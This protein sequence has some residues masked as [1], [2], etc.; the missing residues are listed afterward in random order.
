[1]VMYHQNRYCMPKGTYEPGKKVRI[2]TDEATGIIRFFDFKEGCIIEE[3]PIS[4]GIGK[5]IRNNHPERDKFSN[6]KELKDKVLLGFG[7]NKQS[8]A[9][10][11]TIL[12]KKARYTRDQLSI[13]SKLQDRYTKDELER[14]VSY[15]TEWSLYSASD[16][17]DTL[18]YL[19]QK[20]DAPVIGTVQIPVK[21][22]LVVAQIRPIERYTSLITGG[23]AE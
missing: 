20:K 9:F 22:S 19:C 4:S 1:M 5:C 21:Y 13:F 17:R 11:E 18:E 2:E 8:K 15:C 23:T 10:I 6:H 3:Y 16:F 7:E 14:A 12:S